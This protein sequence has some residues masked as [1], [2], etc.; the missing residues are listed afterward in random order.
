[1]GK[2]FQAVRGQE[3]QSVLDGP[4]GNQPSSHALKHRF[5]IPH[6]SSSGADAATAASQVAVQQLLES[7]HSRQG[8]V[9][10]KTK[11][12]QSQP[13]FYD[14]LSKVVN[15]TNGKGI[16]L[17][18]KLS[19]KSV[20]AAATYL[21]ENG[22]MVRRRSII[23]VYDA[24][25]RRTF[26]M[27]LTE[28]VLPDATPEAFNEKLRLIKSA[29]D[30]HLYATDKTYLDSQIQ[31]NVISLK[32]PQWASLLAAFEDTQI[33]I[34]SKLGYSIH[35]IQQSVQALCEH[36]GTPPEVW[37]KMLD[38]MLVPDPDPNAIAVL[39]PK[40]VQPVA[41]SINSNSTSKLRQT[42][43]DFRRMKNHV[44]T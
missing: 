35:D 26:E 18:E 10:L 1:M 34:H 5:C 4:G 27:P 24:T 6:Q 31:P 28:I 2:V 8:L 42:P 40:L 38:D 33:R 12:E 44:V 3:V 39:K 21:D 19:I 32:V 43:D 15:A 41:A 16:K 22:D 14:E 23:K 20:K 30:A 29:M 11:A 25:L 37:G 36:T 7:A 13:S 9:Q 17:N